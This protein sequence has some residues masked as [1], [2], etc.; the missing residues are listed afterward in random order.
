MAAAVADAGPAGFTPAGAT[1]ILIRA[2]HPEDSADSMRPCVLPRPL[3]ARL[4]ARCEAVAARAPDRLVRAAGG[5]PYLA[6]WYLYPA[7]A[8]RRADAAR[9]ALYLHGFH[10]SDVGHLHD[11]PWPSLSVIVRGEYIEHVPADRR[12]PAGATRAR[13]RRPGDVVLRRARSPHRIE[14]PAGQERPVLTLFAV[15]RR[16]RAW[17]FWCPRGW[18]D[19]P[20]FKRTAA[21][22]GEPAGGCE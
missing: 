5:G 10:D 22:R 12:H 20:A 3:L 18:R 16:R 7:A 6:R 13:R 14:I 9:P 4:R 19:G 2:D 15:G 17:G 8:A 11:H 1:A 21:A